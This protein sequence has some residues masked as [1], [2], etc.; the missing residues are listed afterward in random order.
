MDEYDESLSGKVYDGRVARRLGAYLKPYGHWIVVG[1]VLLVVTAGLEVAGPLILREAIDGHIAQGDTDTLPALVALYLG[2]LLA[3]FALR[4]AQAVL[5]NYV[6]QRVMMDM[7]LQLFS[8]LQRMAIAYFDRNPVGRLVTRLTNDISTLEQVLS[9]G[10]VQIITSLLTVIAIMVAMLV[11]DWKLALV[12]FVFLP[13]L[14]R[15]VM[16]FA[17]TQRDGYREQRAWLARINAYLNENLSGIAVVQLFNREQENLAASTNATG[18]FWGRTCACSGGT[19]AS[20]RRSSSSV[21]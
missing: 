14:V 17:W 9:Q 7:R 20:N 12:M 1:V 16:F 13:L 2:T 19:P 4:Y 21:R 11:I 15:A 6:G 18:G 3:I 8:H 10:V 5:M